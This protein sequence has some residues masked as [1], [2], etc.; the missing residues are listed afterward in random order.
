MRVGVSDGDSR[1]GRTRA[2][3]IQ[4]SK[5]IPLDHEKNKNA[6][7]FL[8]PFVMAIALTLATTATAIPTTA[9][10]TV[11]VDLHVNASITL[12]YDEPAFVATCPVT[13]Q[14]GDTV[15]DV[16]DQAEQD[17]CIQDWTYTS[18]DFGRFVTSIHGPG[19]P[20]PTE[21]RDTDNVNFLCGAPD[22]PIADPMFFS[23][24][25]LFV[26]GEDPG[27]GINDH[28][29]ANGDQ[30]EF[31][32]IIDTCTFAYSLALFTTGPPPTSPVPLAGNE[33]TDPD[34]LPM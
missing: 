12:P 5:V 7:P 24:W 22:G 32:Y 1:P 10:T 27:V 8:R 9:T 31:A 3:N 23:F 6:S 15:Q 25:A 26:N 30:I 11:T 14:A 34:T 13:V 33:N 20:V 21:G 29:V 16:L 18:F 17:A 28:N 4:N 2:T 19:E